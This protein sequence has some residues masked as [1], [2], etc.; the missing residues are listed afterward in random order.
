MT[1]G[2]LLIQIGI[3]LAVVL[4]SVYSF[5]AIQDLIGKPSSTKGLTWMWIGITLGLIIDI[6]AKYWNVVLW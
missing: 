1:I 6:I 2:E 4:Y 3:W 5:F